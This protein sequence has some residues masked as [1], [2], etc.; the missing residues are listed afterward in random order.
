MNAF[1][2]TGTAPSHRA[3][4][5]RPEWHAGDHVILEI[6]LENVEGVR[7]SARNGADRAELC[8]NLAAGGTTPSIG[9]IEAAIFAA[10]EEVE[11][12]RAVAGPHWETTPAAAPFGIR[13]T[14]RPRGG[15]FVYNSDE[16]RS[17]IS[18]IRRI[19][20]LSR[21][22]SEFTQ[23]QRTG[24][25][26]RELPPLVELGFVTGAL[27]PDHDVDRGLLRLLIDMAD[28]AP[29]TFHRA[30][31]V[32]RDPIEAYGVLGGLGVDYVRTSGG[33]PTA[34]EGAEV[35][36]G[37]VEAG[38]D[39][40][41]PTIIGAGAVRPHNLEE[42]VRAAGIHE[43]H[44]RCSVPGSVPEAPQRTD[45]SQVRTAVAAAKSVVGE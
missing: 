13:V 12:R 44:M 11:Q 27:T 38:K 7:I 5:K 22:L 21:E 26:G 39:T 10:A 33:A 34:L 28:G 25:A 36:R 6:C 42:V 35:L 20:A 32:T 31:D 30:I 41:G 2:L 23:P 45:E 16:G 3:H 18:D 4:A 19:S 9:A 37:M 40:E 43:I 24:N 15:D 8:D 29:V 14:I 1:R 17:M